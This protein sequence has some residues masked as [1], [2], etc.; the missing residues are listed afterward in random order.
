LA[1]GPHLLVALSAVYNMNDPLEMVVREYLPWV[2]GLAALRLQELGLSQSKIARALGVTQPSVALYLKREKDYYYAKTDALRVPRELVASQV[3]QCAQAGSSG[4]LES[5]YSTLEIASEVLGGGSLCAHHREV[6]GLPE[7]CDV[8]MRFFGTGGRGERSSML[9]DLESSI[10]L[11]EASESFPL[12]IPGVQTNFVSALPDALD[13]KDVAGVAGRIANVKGHARAASAPE[14]GASR[15][16]SGIV[17]AMKRVFKEVGS[18]M[19]VRYDPLV[20][21]LIASLGW[22]RLDL[23][24]GEGDSGVSQ[25][26]RKVA[27]AA[28][29]MSGPPDILVESGGIGLEASAYIIGGSPAEVVEKA[30]T[31]A[32]LYSRYRRPPR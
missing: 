5:V 18:G 31:L 13:A 32:G 3:G 20:G 19:N 22:R 9:R 6:A 12:L 7:S 15:Y 1:G 25:L 28:R 11:I 16:T 26:S 8:C 21:E 24:S 17:L 4:P 30:L 10:H 29:K 2:R 14:F 27:T 23:T